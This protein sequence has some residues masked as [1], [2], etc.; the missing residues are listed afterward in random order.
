MV[1]LSIILTWVIGFV[2]LILCVFSLYIFVKRVKYET[3]VVL[4]IVPIILWLCAEIVFYL[5]RQARECNLNKMC[6]SAIECQQQMAENLKTMRD[7]TIAI[8]TLS[9]IMIAVLFGCVCYLVK[10]F[11]LDGVRKVL[12][13]YS[14]PVL[15]KGIL[16]PKTQDVDPE[17]CP[18]WDM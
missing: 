11:H 12:Y 2:K 13:N 3:I 6:T 5:D 15:S 14:M 8:V 7:L 9:Y 4:S 1:A 10:C 18:V 16:N 17:S